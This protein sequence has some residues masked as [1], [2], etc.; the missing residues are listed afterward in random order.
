[1]RGLAEKAGL[2]V[3]TEDPDA[4]TRAESAANGGKVRDPE[5][6]QKKNAGSDTSPTNHPPKSIK[7]QLRAAR[8]KLHKRLGKDADAAAW[9]ALA[10]AE[11]RQQHNLEAVAALTES[12]R[13][14]PAQPRVHYQ[15]GA[16]WSDLGEWWRRGWGSSSVFTK[17]HS[18]ANSP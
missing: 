5:R 15:I 1:M 16:L 3:T 18:I 12:V 13:L 4:I 7:R 10:E 8:T 6:T 17:S 14:D 9:L 2:P 11:A